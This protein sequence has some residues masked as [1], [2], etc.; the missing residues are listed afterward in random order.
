MARPQAADGET[1]SKMEDSA[2]IINKQSPA[3]ENGRSTSMG[4]G[5]ILTTHQ[6]RNWHC[7]ETDR[8]SLA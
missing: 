7:Y 4:L 3:A 6:R 2:N 5:E 8:L 1:A